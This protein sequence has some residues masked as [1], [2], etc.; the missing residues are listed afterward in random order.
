MRDTKAKN[1]FHIRDDEI[2]HGKKHVF[3]IKRRFLQPQ[4]ERSMCSEKFVREKS[5]EKG[6]GKEES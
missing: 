3:V 5:R 6:T 2:A 1:I 4:T